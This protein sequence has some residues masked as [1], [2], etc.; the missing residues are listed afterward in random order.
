VEKL[1]Y[2]GSYGDFLR[3]YLQAYHGFC[4]GNDCLE[5]P[6]WNH[7]WF[8]AYLWVY[9]MVLGGLAVLAGGAM[10]RVSDRMG[11]WL[12]GWKL[13]AL[14]VAVLWAARMLLA[15]SFPSTHN[16]TRD[17]YNHALYLFLFLLGAL[18]ATQARVWQ[19]M[20]R[21]RWAALALWLGAWAVVVIVNSLPEGVLTETQVQLWRPLWRVA[22]CCDQWAPILALCGFGRRHLNFD[23][24]KRRHLTQAVFPVYILHQTLI[25]TMAHWLKPVGLAPFTEG[26]VLVILTLAL[27]FAGFE[28][29]RRVALLRPFFGLGRT[30]YGKSATAPAS[31]QHEADCLP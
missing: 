5:L 22:Y 6:T 12:T 9:T 27:S 7:L 23:S 20:E 30:G 16:L 11:S 26:M 17:W 10:Q 4:R 18:I 25:V 14:P 28:I 19:E 1:A 2:Q 8:V 31:R 21:L 15:D 3:L 29:V 13:V 24:A